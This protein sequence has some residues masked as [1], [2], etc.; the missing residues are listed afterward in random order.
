MFVKFD[1]AASCVIMKQLTENVTTKS[2]NKSIRPICLP[3]LSI[4]RSVKQQQD[5][6]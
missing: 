5:C 6:I 4:P 1:S 3:R 2:K